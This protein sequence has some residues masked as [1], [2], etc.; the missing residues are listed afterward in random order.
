MHQ[1]RN[2]I[3]TAV[4][5]ACASAL[6]ACGGG[7][8]G[9]DPASQGPTIPSAPSRDTTPKT[10]SL[11][12]D[13]IGLVAYTLLTSTKASADLA[14]AT[15]GA[16]L[17]TVGFALWGLSMGDDPTTACQVSGT[18]RF[19][20]VDND[21]DTELSTGDS[22]TITNVGCQPSSSVTMDGKTVID[23]LQFASATNPGDSKI[24]EMKITH[25]DD[26]TIDSLGESRLD[27]SMT[28]ALESQE[29][30]DGSSVDVSRVDVS[31]L[32]SVAEG[33]TTTLSDWRASTR[34][35]EVRGVATA[36]FAAS[37]STEDSTIGGYTFEI[38]V[39]FVTVDPPLMA[40]GP[41]TAGKFRAVMADKRSVTLIVKDETS[42]LV[43]ADLD[44]DGTNELSRD[45]SW[46]DLG[47]QYFTWLGYDF[48]GAAA[49]QRSVMR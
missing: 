31:K 18:T 37:G 32:V 33:V 11:T 43:E 15:A 48:S 5:M 44:G 26:V 19:D 6:S 24:T 8:G 40:I 16:N 7:G 39:P 27:G 35:T 3:S 4:I 49:M 25:V 46:D 41:S 29:L 2:K 1:T 47:I 12:S 21:G 45:Y 14:T 28:V 30:A 17:L 13:S 34:T 23:V 22:A 42:V 10:L 38:P 36:S 20:F 9:G